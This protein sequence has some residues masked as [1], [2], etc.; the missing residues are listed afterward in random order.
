LLFF[1]VPQLAVILLGSVT[2]SQ[3]APHPDARADQ[4]PPYGVKGKV[5]EPRLFA[6]GVI[7]TV[8]D[9]IGGSFSPDGNDFYFTRLVPYTT[10][11]RL[12]I[13][14]VSHYAD[15]HWGAPEVLPFSGKNLDFPPRFDSSGKRML[16]ASSRSLPD[17]THGGIRIWEVERTATGWGEPRPLPP[18]VNPAGSHWSGD[19]S[20]ADDGTL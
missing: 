20:V 4:L 15:G 3:A 12:G 7:S 6:E 1:R 8:D 16:F 11:P 17:G 13:M 2:W 5:L 10:Y 18:P 14:C 9:E 19:P